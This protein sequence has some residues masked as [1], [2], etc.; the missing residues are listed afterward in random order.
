MIWKSLD[1]LFY[2]D[3]GMSPYTYILSLS[4]LA[5]VQV[6]SFGH[7]NTSGS[8]NMDYF[9]SSK[10]TE[11]EDSDMY[12]TERLIR[13]SR[14]PFNIQK[15]SIKNAHFNRSQL[16]IPSNSFL[17]GIKTKLTSK[18]PASYIEKIIQQQI[19]NK[20]CD[21]EDILKCVKLILSKDSSKI[22]GEN[23]IIGGY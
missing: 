16:N 11:T 2:P 5:L 8:K 12:Y 1:I 13:F 6:T 21:K 4:R 9:I 3:I 19:I 15:P 23:F 22:T 18:V 14:L 17:I 7:P 20:Q 10:Y